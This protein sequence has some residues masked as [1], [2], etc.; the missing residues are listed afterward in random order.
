MSSTRAVYGLREVT[1]YCAKKGIMFIRSF[2]EMID[3]ASFRNGE[4]QSLVAL[5]WHAIQPRPN[6]HSNRCD[7]NISI[8]NFLCDKVSFLKFSH[9]RIYIY[10]YI[11]RGSFRG[12]R[13]GT[14]PPLTKSRPPLEI[15]SLQ[16]ASHVHRTSPPL[17]FINTH[18]APLGSISK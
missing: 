2:L 4:I 6:Y 5:E 3:G 18:F 13:G 17:F 9:I 14:R 1:E 12:G 10:I 8:L 16:S 7:T 15:A 11:Y